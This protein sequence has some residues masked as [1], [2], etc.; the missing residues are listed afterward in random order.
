MRVIDA[1]RELKKLSDAGLANRELKY[2][3]IDGKEYPIAVV[4]EDDN[5]GGDVGFV[6]LRPQAS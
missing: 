1:A 5:C 2:V 3:D 6:A 4:E